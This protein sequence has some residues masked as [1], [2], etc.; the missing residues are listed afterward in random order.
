[1]PSGYIGS[2]IKSKLTYPIKNDTLHSYSR[3]KCHNYVEV[4]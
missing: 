2:P 3:Y 4:L 1:M